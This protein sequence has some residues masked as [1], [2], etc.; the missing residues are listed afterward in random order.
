MKMTMMMMMIGLDGPVGLVNFLIVL[1]LPQT[2]PLIRQLGDYLSQK[3]QEKKFHPT[4]EL[5]YWRTNFFSMNNVYISLKF[6]PT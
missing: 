2:T 3:I 4:L 1:S 5:D 6:V